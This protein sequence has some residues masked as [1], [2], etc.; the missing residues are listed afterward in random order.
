MLSMGEYSILPN[1][2][3]DTKS[4]HV[5]FD[6]V[7]TRQTPLQSEAY[8]QINRSIRNSIYKIVDTNI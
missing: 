8:G 1:K 4:I 7:A 2:V 6:N 3:K 5:T